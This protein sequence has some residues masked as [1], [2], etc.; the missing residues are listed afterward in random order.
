[1]S[2]QA[3]NCWLP[4]PAYPLALPLVN[5]GAETGDTTGWTSR[6]GGAPQAG[7]TD[8]GVTPYEGS[9]YLRA[10]ASGQHAEWDQPI[11]LPANILAHVDAGLLFARASARHNGIAADGDNGG[12]YLD[13]RDGAAALISAKQ[14]RHTHVAAS[15]DEEFVT[16]PIPANTRTIRVGTMNGRSGG[17]QLSTYWEFGANLEINIGAYSDTNSAMPYFFNVGVRADNASAAAGFNVV[18]PTGL[19]ANDIAIIHA[20][21]IDNLADS[22]T[23][24][25]P[26]DFT[27][28]GQGNLRSFAYRKHALFYKRL[29]GSES[30]NVAMSR[31]GT[32]SVND[33][34]TAVMA[35]F[36]GCIASGTPYEALA[37]NTGNGT[38]LDC[39]GLTTLGADRLVLHFCGDTGDN[40]T[41]AAGWLKVYDLN[42]TSGVNDAG[43]KTFSKEQ[44]AAAAVA[45]ASHSIDA[46]ADWHTF[47]LALKPA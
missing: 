16:A 30:G 3:V 19:K 13:F 34:F 25:T 15:W 28:I 46:S 29:T 42:S 4:G 32:L 11:T 24:N 8:T 23:I 10:T 26:T 39:A 22:H 18:Y 37:S 5:P 43:L 40:A 21:S 36:R 45:A 38:T 9:W 41:A 7:Q 1:V 17:T 12:L 35:I 14:Q 44:A 27:S 33:D 20:V 47:S 6:S 31:T 2:I